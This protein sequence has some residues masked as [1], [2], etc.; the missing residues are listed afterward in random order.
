MAAQQQVN[1]NGWQARATVG[2]ALSFVE[3]LGTALW[4][5]HGWSSVGESFEMATLGVATS[6][7][8]PYVRRSARGIIE[9]SVEA[10]RGN[11]LTLGGLTGRIATRIPRTIASGYIPETL[12][13]LFSTAPVHSAQD[14]FHHMATHAVRGAAEG[15][16]MSFIAPLAVYGT[17]RVVVEPVYRFLHAHNWI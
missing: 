14:Y 11:P 16:I 17:R 4:R 15:I 10:A 3:K 8:F 7:F 12:Y 1:L 5:G 13:S 2:G 9:N 6:A